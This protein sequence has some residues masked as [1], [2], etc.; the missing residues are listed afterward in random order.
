MSFS[1]SAA[2]GNLLR[3]SLT[4]NLESTSMSSALTPMTLAPSAAN[5][6]TASANSCASCVQPGVKAAG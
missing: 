1:A 2:T 6:S 3:H 4:E 5:L